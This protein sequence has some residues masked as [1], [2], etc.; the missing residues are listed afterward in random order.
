MDN[1]R[2]QLCSGKMKRNVHIPVSVGEK[3]NGVR[4][5]GT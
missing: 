5:V 4:N 1:K 3:G 2:C